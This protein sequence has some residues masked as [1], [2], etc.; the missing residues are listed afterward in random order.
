MERI[1]ALRVAR[2]FTQRDLA[3]MLRTTQQTIARWESGKAEPSVSALRDLATIF[4]T[5]VDDLL[6]KNPFSD[7]LVTNSYY[8][9]QDEGDGFWGHLGLLVPGQDKSTWYPITNG[10][11][12]R[13]WRHLRSDENDWLVVTSLN[14]RI[15]TFRADRM[16]RVWLLD[17]ACDQPS[18]D[19]EWK[20][21]WDD[22]S[23]LP[24]ELYRAMSE[25]AWDQVGGLDDFSENNSPTLQEIAID[26][27]KEANLL[28]QPERILEVIHHTKIHMMDSAHYGY[29]VDPDELWS[30]IQNVEID[31]P[32]MFY[33]PKAGGDFDSFFPS[34]QVALIDMPLIDVEEAAK[35]AIQELESA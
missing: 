15:L 22:Y 5:S 30:A 4:S 25:W 17:D 12:E 9:L 26:K 29:E 27:I 16:Q 33:L 1:K 34:A 6:G 11:R 24:K 20:T 18:E 23:G 31:A 10:E 7:K 35:K 13:V 32:K 19:W 21:L 3:T 28:D 2:N 14:N 8:I